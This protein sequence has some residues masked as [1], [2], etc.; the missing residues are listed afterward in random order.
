MYVS[1]KLT[2]LCNDLL[3]QLGDW[4]GSDLVTKHPQHGA[5]TDSMLRHLN[6]LPCELCGHQRHKIQREDLHY[7]LQHV[8]CLLVHCSL[9]HMPSEA[10][11][12]D[13]SVSKRRFLLIRLLQPMCHR[14]DCPLQKPARI[15]ILPCKLPQVVA[16]RSRCDVGLDSGQH[17]SLTSQVVRI[18]RLFLFCMLQHGHLCFCSVTV[19][20]TRRCHARAAAPCGGSCR[21]PTSNV[22]LIIW[23]H[24]LCCPS[25]HGQRFRKL[26]C[27]LVNASSKKR[28]GLTL[29][30]PHC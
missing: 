16:T 25:A 7:A 21:T 13:L 6:C 10:V 12:D 11:Q 8:I 9:N 3:C 2:G 28:A 24:S 23:I 4:T 20:A 18:L 1:A 19:T 17:F 26:L 29:H 14:E 5:T 22:T 30:S 27:G 15:L